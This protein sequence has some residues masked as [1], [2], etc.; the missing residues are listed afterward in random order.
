M[1]FQY[2]LGRR[3]AHSVQQ[4]VQFRVDEVHLARP[5]FLQFCDSTKRIRMTANVILATETVAGQCASTER[6]ANELPHH[7]ASKKS[8]ETEE[9][10]GEQIEKP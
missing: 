1:A 4:Q 10:M 2:I 6:L 9:T 3:I 8:K 7:T 5:H